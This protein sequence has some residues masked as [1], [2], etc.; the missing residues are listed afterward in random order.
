GKSLIPAI[1]A[2]IGICGVRVGMIFFM[3][4]TAY[5]YEYLMSA[6]PISWIIT[7]SV[8]AIACLRVFS[9]IRQKEKMQMQS[10]PA[11]A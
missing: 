9:Q 11:L 6:Y 4:Q 3:P 1:T 8:L 2:I 7:F 10:I 5:P